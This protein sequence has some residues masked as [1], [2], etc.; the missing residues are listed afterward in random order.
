MTLGRIWNRWIQVDNTESRRLS[1]TSSRED[2]H[3]TRLALMDRAAPSQ[4]LSQELGSFARPSHQD[5]RIRVR[6]HRGERTL[7]ACICHSRAGTSPCVME[8]DAIGYTSRSPL[9]RPLLG[10]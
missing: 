7:A 1:I 5:G 9:V 2:R 4:A 3:V 8:W 6:W 10:H